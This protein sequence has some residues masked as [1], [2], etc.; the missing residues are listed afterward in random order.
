MGA[1]DLTNE[2]RIAAGVAPEVA[3]VGGDHYA[4]RYQHWDWV[5]DCRVP[6]LEA[7]ATKYLMRWR[8]KNGTQDL[9][10][11]LS[12]VVK[13]RAAQHRGYVNTSHQE[14]WAVDKMSHMFGESD[15]LP[16]HLTDRQAIRQIARWR[17]D[18]DLQRAI[19][20]INVLIQEAER[21]RK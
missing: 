5:I 21:G 11:A 6:Y 8:K 14:Q 19:D 12:Y 16:E 7:N 4:A 18:D 9:N 17:T 15:M 10:K 2:E 20:S 13:I 3:Q 1:R